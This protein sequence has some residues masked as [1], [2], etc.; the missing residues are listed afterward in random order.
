MV[1]CALRTVNA[2]QRRLL[3]CLDATDQHC[4]DDQEHNHSDDGAQQDDKPRLHQNVVRV[5]VRDWVS[6]DHNE[7]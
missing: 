6:V 2:A 5:V 4:G 3:H 7:T 1:D